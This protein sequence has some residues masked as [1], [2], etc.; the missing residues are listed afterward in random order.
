MPS[1]K[2]Q[3]G[4]I[5]A[6]EAS[7][8]TEMSSPGFVRLANRLNIRRLVRAGSPPLY[9]EGDVAA[10][11]TRDQI[12]GVPFGIEPEPEPAGSVAS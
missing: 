11:A 4:W 7:H 2:S 3:D 8:R 10:I 6:K 5:T 1:K 9:H 12:I